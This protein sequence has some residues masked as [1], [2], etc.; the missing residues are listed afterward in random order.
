M[1]KRKA[2]YLLDLLA[3]LVLLVL[4]RHLACGALAQE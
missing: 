2:A 4:V 1:R 3:I